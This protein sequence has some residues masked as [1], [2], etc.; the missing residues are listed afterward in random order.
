M[1]LQLADI[2][3]VAL[4]GEPGSDKAFEVDGEGTV[5]RVRLK[6]AEQIA[7][8]FSATGGVA[9]IIEGFD[10]TLTRLVDGEVMRDAFGRVVFVAHTRLTVDEALKA[11]EGFSY[12]T[13]FDRMI[14]RLIWEAER[15]READET[16][17]AYLLGEW[18]VEPPAPVVVDRPHP[19]SIQ[20]DLD[21]LEA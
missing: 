1:T 4:E 10:L 21:A 11:S 18:G 2:T 3:P 19:P 16:G 9:P 13:E 6:L 7:P 12:A 20:A 15:R 8:A 17:S 14:R 5:Y